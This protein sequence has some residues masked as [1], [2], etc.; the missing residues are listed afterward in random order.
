MANRKDDLEIVDAEDDLDAPVRRAPKNERDEQ[1]DDELFDPLDRNIQF[2]EDKDQEDD[3]VENEDTEDRGTDEDEDEPVSRRARDEDD[4]DDGRGSEQW[5]RR[6]ARERRLRE[7]AE[8]DADQYQQNFERVN[9][10]LDEIAGKLETQ[11]ST[12]EL[13]VKIEGL[14]SELDK[15]KVALKAAVEAGDSDKVVDLQ[16]KLSDV[17]GDIKIAEYQKTQVKTVVDAGKETPPVVNRHLTRW[18]RQHGTKYRGDAVFKK[19]AEAI[20]VELINEGY[21]GTDPEHFAMLDRRLSKLYPKEFPRIRS[22]GRRSRAPISGDTDSGGAPPRPRERGDNL[23]LKVRGNKVQLSKRH[24]SIM[25][26]FG[27]DP[28]DKADRLTFAR[29]NLPARKR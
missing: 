29:E 19:A 15:I 1:T 9:K 24:E 16:E 18:M 11:K 20:S 5:R 3:D 10:R 4:E 14:K 8:S 12:A 27:M 21:A 6:L 23:D 25:E 26:K 22:E 17:K 13:D 2:P 7:E 28:D